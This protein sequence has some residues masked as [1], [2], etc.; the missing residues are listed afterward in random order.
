MKIKNLKEFTSYLLENNFVNQAQLNDALNLSKKKGL[1]L[2]QALVEANAINDEHLGQLIATHNN[3]KF[4]NLKK[5]IIDHTLLRKIPEEVARNQQIIAYKKSQFGIEIATNDPSNTILI[6]LL[7]KKLGQNLNIH[8]ATVNDISQHFKLYKSDIGKEFEDIIAVQEEKTI[9]NYS[10]TI[11]IVNMLLTRGYEKSAS[12]IHIDPTENDTSIRF[13]IDG[14]MHDIIN[15]PRNI[16]ESLISRIKVM[17]H[18]RTDEHQV[19]QDGKLRF[20]INGEKVDVRVSIVP[21][22]K[23]ENVV[24]R[25]L[26]EKSKQYALEELGL[27]NKDYTK[28]SKAIKKPWGMILSTGPTGSGKT[29]ML[30]SIL[31]ILNRS[32]VHIATIEDPVEYNVDEI[33][34]IQVN[35]KTKLTFGEGLKSIVRQD[36]DIIMVGEIRDK[37]TAGIA[38]NSA[39][40]GH[41]VL[42]TL[43]TNDASTTLP[44]IL[45]MG[46]EPFLIASTANIA[47]GQRLVRKICIKC[48]QSYETT[49]DSLKEK[50]P[51]SIA[52]KIMGDK[53]TI[54]TYEGKGC[55][56]CNHTGYH[57][58]TG[59]FE[60]LEIDNDIK[61]MIMENA[62]ADEVKKKAVE[63]GMTTMFDDALDKALNGI[64]TVEELFRVIK[65]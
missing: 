43:H 2:D 57:G 23:G 13:R 53:K 62:D 49:V 63:K 28:L 42:S 61:K 3:W 27:S 20:E 64:I 35:P 50:V 45:D 52:E 58:R 25:L 21:T 31:K 46:I 18:L 26:S 6:H 11:Q 37:E 19:P 54:M 1:P 29:T 24:M 56:L 17:S 55:D 14:V 48:V 5:E 10:S 47:I 33:T 4:I 38:I 44:R 65:I 22:T 12:D 8:Y 30:Y 40:T 59:V 16:H 39:M 15:I 9:K 7:T 34:Q 41:L 60:I 36:P 51:T 32:E